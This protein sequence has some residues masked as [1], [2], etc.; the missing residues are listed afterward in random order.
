VELPVEL[1]AVLPVE[2]LVVLPVACSANSVT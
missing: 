1:L 2:L